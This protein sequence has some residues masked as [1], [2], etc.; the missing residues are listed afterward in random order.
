MEKDKGKAREQPWTTDTV[1]E[2]GGTEASAAAP[3]VG[4]RWSSGREGEGPHVCREYYN[5]N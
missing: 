2:W 1:M 5:T 3:K 4:I